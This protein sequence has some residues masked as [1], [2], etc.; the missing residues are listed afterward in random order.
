[1]GCFLCTPGGGALPSV[2][3]EEP[4][5]ST[6]AGW[7]RP[8]SHMHITISLLIVLTAFVDREESLI[9][10]GVGSRTTEVPGGLFWNSWE[11]VCPVG[12]LCA[13][14]GQHCGSSKR[15]RCQNLGKG[16][17]LFIDF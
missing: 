14:Y 3:A 5:I 6:I 13:L 2:F 17:F 12:V 16:V 15:I 7:S 9:V 10:E 1:M 8:H 4:F 11:G